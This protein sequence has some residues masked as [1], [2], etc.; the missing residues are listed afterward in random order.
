MRGGLGAGFDTNTDPQE[1]GFAGDAGDDARY[2]GSDAEVG[3]NPSRPSSMPDSSPTR[4]V[5]SNVRGWTA[6]YHLT[7]AVPEGSTLQGLYDDGRSADLL[8]A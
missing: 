4:T 5:P 3:P 2:I 8:G 6:R 1:A 7:W